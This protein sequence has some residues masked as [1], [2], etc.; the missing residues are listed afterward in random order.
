MARMLAPFGAVFAISSAPAK[1]APL[2]AEEVYLLDATGQRLAEYQ[3]QETTGAVAYADLN[4]D[5]WDDLLVC[6][7]YLSQ[8]P[9]KDL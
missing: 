9:D 2:D 1:V 3:L 4:N 6:N 7:G 8:E 5:G